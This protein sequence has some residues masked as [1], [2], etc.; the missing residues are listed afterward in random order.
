MINRNKKGV[1]LVELVICCAI[2]V[3]LGGACTALLMSGNTIYNRSSASANA[4][5]DADV[6]QTYM[7]NILPRCNKVKADRLE[8]SEVNC[9]Y[10]NGDGK[11]C[12]E[13]GGS[14]TTITAISKL[15][16]EVV[17]AGNSD[18]SRAQLVYTVTLDDG[19]TFTSGFVLANLPYSDTEVTTANGAQVPLK[20]TIAYDANAETQAHLYF[21]I[22]SA[23]ATEP[24]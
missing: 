6:L 21:G 5:L 8:G 3:M 18:T 14:V 9:I 13:R 7:L 2:I 16:Y 1:T 19:S 17:K 12:L 23:E 4:Q 11:F 22:S 10:F 15:E 24:A 20:G